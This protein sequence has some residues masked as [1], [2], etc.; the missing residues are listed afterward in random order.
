MNEDKTVTRRDLL[1]GA[2]VAGL[3]L[4]APSLISP[5]E[6]L[7]GLR[8]AYRVQR[9]RANSLTWLTYALYSD[10]R[11]TKAFTQQSGISIKGDNFGELPEMETKL[12][13]GAGDDV[14]SIAS[15]L[16]GPLAAEGLLLPLD[17]SRM[18]NWKRL[19]PQFSEANFIRYKGKI[20]GAPTVWGP[21]GLIY[22]TD[23]LKG[24]NSWDVLWDPKNKGQLSVI[25][26]DYEMALVGALYLGMKKQLSGNPIQFSSADL[27]KIKS[28][29]MEQIKLDS[30]VWSDTAVAEALLA[31]GESVATIGRIAFLKDLKAKNVPVKLINPKEGTQGWVTSTC[32]VAKSQ[33]VDAAYKFLD[34]AISPGYGVPLAQT[35]GY[36]ATSSQVM[37]KIPPAQRRELFLNDPKILEK[38]YFWKPAPQQAQITQMWNEVKASA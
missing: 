9:A 19:Y 20:Y 6:A 24:V 33:N 34:Y 23:K 11:L 8:K 21:E 22:R 3:A 7:G 29:L 12:R 13:A 1:K 37:L 17:T 5:A 36:P 2:A 35:Y 32:I 15:N 28:A 38:M 31:S 14:V 4:G 30:K 18:K 10:P 27:A 25:D 26:Y 16:V